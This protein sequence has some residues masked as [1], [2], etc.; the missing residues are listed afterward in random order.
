VKEFREALGRKEGEHGSYNHIIVGEVFFHLEVGIEL[1]YT[2]VLFCHKFVIFAY[3]NS[4]LM[5]I[6]MGSRA[7]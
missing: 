6:N 7:S 5:V 4:I 2:M 3:T 1:W